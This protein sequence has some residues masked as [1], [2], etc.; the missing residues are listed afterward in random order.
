MFEPTSLVL[1]YRI[2]TEGNFF[3][4]RVKNMENAYVQKL[5]FIE[6]NFLILL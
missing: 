2:F 3:D 1:Q 5:L 6:K 4:N